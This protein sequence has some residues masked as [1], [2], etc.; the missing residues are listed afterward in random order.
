MPEPQGQDTPS[1]STPNLTNRTGIR[2]QRPSRITPA[3]S[4]NH[5]PNSAQPSWNFVCERQANSQDPPNPI[6]GQA[7]PTLAGMNK[8]YYISETNKPSKPHLTIDLTVLI[9]IP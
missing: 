9:S 5:A 1:Q 6:R 4:I 8:H 2:G 7:P 3:S